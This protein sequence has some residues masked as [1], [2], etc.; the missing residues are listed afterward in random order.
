MTPT[1]VRVKRGEQSSEVDAVE[2]EPR[3]GDVL[4][5][6]YPEVKL[7]LKIKFA[8]VDVGG[9]SYTRTLRAGDNV[10]EQYS[11]V[12][13]FLKRNAERDAI[14]K[15]KHWDSAFSGSGREG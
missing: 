12:Y 13:A 8:I 14:E 2:F 15:V 4:V 7:P 3:D 11:K 5:V 6:S 1:R 10:Q 9:T